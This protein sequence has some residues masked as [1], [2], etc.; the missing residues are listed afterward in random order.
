MDGYQVKR[1]SVLIDAIHDNVN[2][3]LDAAAKNGVN[4][5]VAAVRIAEERI[6]DV[7]SL[8]LDRRPGHHRGGLK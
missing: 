5:H 2:R 3:V 8:R 7:G 1:A 6:Q 4:P